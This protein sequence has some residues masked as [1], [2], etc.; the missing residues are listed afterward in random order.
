MIDI[1]QEILALR[2]EIE[3]A[4]RRTYG[5][6]DDTIESEIELEYLKSRLEYQMSDTS[7]D[8]WLNG[9]C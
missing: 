7:D 3:N 5:V 2:E 6:E 8:E 4:K 1:L 9:G